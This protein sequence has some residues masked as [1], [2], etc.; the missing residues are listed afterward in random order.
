[1]S[2]D[3]GRSSRYLIS[4]KFTSTLNLFGNASDISSC[5][6][7]SFERCP[8]SIR[9]YDVQKRMSCD[10]PLRC[11]TRAKQTFDSAFEC[12]FA[13]SLQ[14]WDC[15]G[16]DCCQ[17]T[18]RKSSGKCFQSA[19]WTSGYAQIGRNPDDVATSVKEGCQPHLTQRSTGYIRCRQIG[20]IVL[21]PPVQH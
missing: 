17:S 8:W 5:F 6:Q 1:M 2:S 11:C 7:I 19:C 13:S 18:S 15:Q 20:S 9:S 21:P 3:H 10:F 4:M 16:I 14:H 12:S